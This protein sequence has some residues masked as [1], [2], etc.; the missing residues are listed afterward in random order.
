MPVNHCNSK[1]DPKIQKF[2]APSAPLIF[3]RLSI[4][5]PFSSNI[6]SIGA[7]GDFFKH[8]GSV[9][10]SFSFENDHFQRQTVVGIPK[11]FS[12]QDLKML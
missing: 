1:S 3:T 5:Y 8:S 11:I 12:I 9:L 4:L 7:A 6:F 2:S 10:N